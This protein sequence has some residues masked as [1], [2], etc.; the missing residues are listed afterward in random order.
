MR[1]SHPKQELLSEVVLGSALPEGSTRKE[2]KKKRDL[3]GSLSDSNSLSTMS[4]SL[5]SIIGFLKKALTMAAI[6]LFYLL[7]FT[8]LPL[9]TLLTKWCYCLNNPFCSLVASE[10][11]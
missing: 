5:L 6:A 8:L 3:G 10:W 11:I 4:L 2:T 7:F 1:S 9:Q